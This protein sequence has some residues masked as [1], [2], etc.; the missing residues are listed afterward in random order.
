MAIETNPV[1][2]T[3]LQHVKA[4]ADAQQALRAAMAQVA[5]EVAASKPATTGTAPSS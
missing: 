3:V 1:R 5:A 4:A 2:D